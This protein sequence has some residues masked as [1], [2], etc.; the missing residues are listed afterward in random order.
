MAE[1]MLRLQLVYPD[2]HFAAYYRSGVYFPISVGR[3]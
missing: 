3:W 1:E 2:I